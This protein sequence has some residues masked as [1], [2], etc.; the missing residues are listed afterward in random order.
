MQIETM[1]LRALL[2]LLFFAFLASSAQAGVSPISLLYPSQHP[3]GLFT[4][5][6]QEQ[7]G[8]LTPAEAEAL[9]RAGKFTATTTAVPNFGIGARPVWLHLAVNNPTTAPLTRRLVLENT[10]LDHVDIYFSSAG[11]RL[12][13]YHMGDALPFTSRPVVGRF[14]T[15]E[16]SFA[17]GTTDLFIRIATPDPMVVPLYLLTADAAR[18]REVRQEYT[19]GLIY[20]SLIALM[21]YNAMLFFSLGSQRFLFYA[22]YLATFLSMNLTYTGHGFAWLWPNS[23]KWQLWSHPLLIF[24]YA[25]SGLM[26]AARFLDTKANFPR[27]HRG[28]IGYSAL[29]GLLMTAAVALHSQVYA[30][31]LS[32]VFVFLFSIIMLVLGTV[33]VRAG[34]KPARYFLIA[35]LAAMIGA[36]LTTLSVWGFIPF[37]NWTYHAVEL[38]MLLDATL[39]ALALAYQFRVGQEERLRAEQLAQK[40]PLTGLNNRRAFYDKTAA[41]WSMAQR[42]GRC[43]SVILLDIDWFKRINDTLGHAHGDK[44]LVAIARLLQASVRQYD[45]VARWGGEEFIVFLPETSPDEAVQ[46][47]QRLRAGI[48]QLHIPHETGETRVTA[49]FGVAQKEAGHATLDALIAAADHLLYQSKQEGRDRISASHF[50]Q[51]EARGN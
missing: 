3:L 11:S 28:L 20:G 22:L 45:I 10:W 14:F 18:E 7:Q 33:S 42:S 32:F 17:P 50:M 46:L 38:G 49:S 23:I 40:D 26:F 35:A 9:Y 1:K 43:V 36:A 8:P 39:L 4:S 19:Y 41:P 2:I 12:S 16:Q 51:C 25:L 34:Y 44:V 29:F 5:S 13:T 24:A 48:A 6:L 21:A 31:L 15:V 47:A 27:L 30:L 37:N